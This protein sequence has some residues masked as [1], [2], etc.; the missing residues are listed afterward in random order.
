MKTRMRNGMGWTLLA[1]ALGASSG[2]CDSPCMKKCKSTA[3]KVS[4]LGETARAMA[5]EALE[6]CLKV[7]EM[8]ED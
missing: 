2:G 3:R 5:D 8:T 6:T 4:E 7:C 1:L